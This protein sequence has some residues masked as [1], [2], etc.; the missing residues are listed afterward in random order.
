MLAFAACSNDGNSNIPDIPDDPA[1]TKTTILSR[2][3]SPVFLDDTGN[4]L[5]LD[6]NGRLHGENLYFTSSK[7][8]DGLSYVTSIP[9]SDWGVLSAVAVQG[10]GLV[11]GSRTFDG[12]TFTR[13]FVDGVD[14]VTGE[15]ALKSLS[16]FYGDVTSFYLHPKDR[17]ILYKEAGDT[18]VVLTKPAT[19]NVE[20]ASGSWAS[21]KPHITHVQ[22][23]YSE[24]MT[25]KMRVDTLI[26]TN[27][28]FAEKRLPVVQLQMSKNDSID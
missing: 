9:L 28:M 24:N 8:C 18:T 25:G 11:M 15:V 7:R 10:E 17:L 19:Y 13:L 1:G 14:D 4:G 16:P 27:G 6:D 20:L 5:C 3:G 21:I 2:G 22:L 23:N 26:F 12:A